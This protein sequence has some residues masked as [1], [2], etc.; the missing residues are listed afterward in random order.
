M[1]TEVVDAEELLSPIALAEFMNAM[2]MFGAR[3]PAWRIGEFLTTITA[4]VYAAVAGRT[5]MESGFRMI[6]ERSARPRVVP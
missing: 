5:R 4:D 2:K 6:G 3:L 1:L